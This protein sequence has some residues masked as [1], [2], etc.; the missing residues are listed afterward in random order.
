MEGV[1]YNL[2]AMKEP[3]YLM[4]MMAT[5]G[6]LIVDDSCR[7]TSRCWIEGGDQARKE[8]TYTPPFDN[9]FQYRHTVDDHN[10]L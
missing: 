6:S 9:H 1:L 3:D 2:W 8:F 5:G 4:K 7:S 10:N